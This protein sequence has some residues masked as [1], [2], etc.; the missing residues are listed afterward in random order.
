MAT[1]YLKTPINDEDIEKLELGDIIFLSGKL[2]TVRDW[3]HQR[4]ASLLKE[5]KL[6]EVPFTLEGAAVLH[7]GPIIKTDHNGEYK[8]VSVGATSSSRFSPFVTPL[9]KAM[10]PKLIVG[11]GTLTSEAVQGLV[12]YKAVFVQAVGGCAALYGTK[13][14][15]VVNRYWPEFGMT[16]SAWEFEV[17]NFGPLSVE[18]DV[19]G[20]SSYERLRKEIIK[21]NLFKIYKELGVNLEK[22]FIWW[23][24]APAGTKK[25]RD[26]ATTC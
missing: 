24:Q 18:V 6:D 9:L 22:D 11:K 21:T 1:Y 10:G 8:A 14:K 13:I 20:R 4:I 17:E 7:A 12:K 3:S 23:P 26:Y 25:A 2:V 19:R 16:D 5:N 15:K